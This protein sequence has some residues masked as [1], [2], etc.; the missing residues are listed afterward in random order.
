MSVFRVV[1]Q[2]SFI[3][4]IESG[5]RPLAPNWWQVPAEAAVQNLPDQR[6]PLVDSCTRQLAIAIQTC[7]PLIG[8]PT[9]FE[10]SAALQF[11]APELD[12]GS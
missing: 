10:P 5:K 6:P 7:R 3:D 1:L 2:T 12:V 8:A 11:L 9:P 4:D